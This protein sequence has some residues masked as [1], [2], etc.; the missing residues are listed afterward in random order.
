MHRLHLLSV[1]CWQGA[2]LCLH[3]QAT[4][5]GRDR[6]AAISIPHSAWQ[7]AGAQKRAFLHFLSGE[8]GQ[9]PMPSSQSPANISKDNPQPL[10]REKSLPPSTS[11]WGST[12]HS[13]LCDHEQVSSSPGLCVPFYKTASSLALPNLS[14][15]LPSARLSFLV[16]SLANK[17]MS[18]LVPALP[19]LVKTQVSGITA[20]LACKDCSPCGSGVELQAGAKGPVSP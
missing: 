10:V 4:V 9:M 15:L 5:T 2:S 1:Q 20:S 8:W 6:A 16:N 17:V 13:V 19:K 14:P 11:G 3:F 7:T 12:P 18:L